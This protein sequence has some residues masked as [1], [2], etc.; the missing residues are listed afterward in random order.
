[1]SDDGQYPPPLLH[2]P[3]LESGTQNVPDNIEKWRQKVTRALGLQFGAHGNDS[4]DAVED[5]LAREAESVAPSISE[6]T[7]ASMHLEKVRALQREY[8]D[9][10]KHNAEVVDRRSP[11]KDLLRGHPA[12]GRPLKFSCDKLLAHWSFVSPHLTSNE[13]DQDAGMGI[14]MPHTVNTNPFSVES[15]RT[16]VEAGD[17]I[18]DWTCRIASK[19]IN[20]IDGSSLQLMCVIP[21]SL[22]LFSP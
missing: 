22:R 4:H 19:L 16:K 1:M 15:A 14:F 3:T 10:K 21:S 17:K 7:T 2:P 20:N 12:D 9:F 8:R 6:S 18:S 13:A 11:L 5:I